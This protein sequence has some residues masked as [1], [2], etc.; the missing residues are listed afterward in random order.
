MLG[1]PPTRTSTQ[2][3]PQDGKTPLGPRPRNVNL[4]QLET[5]ES[6]MIGFPDKLTQ[7]EK[8]LLMED[9]FGKPLG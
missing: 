6:T 3:Q 5:A 9:M 7:P 2:T 8:E 4:L 1:P